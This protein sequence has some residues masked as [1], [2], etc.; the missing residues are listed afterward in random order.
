MERCP[1]Y[2]E[3]SKH[4]KAH[5]DP[6]GVDYCIHIYNKIPHKL[7]ANS[8]RY[9]TLKYKFENIY[10]T[11]C[12][13]VPII[14]YFKTNRNIFAVSA[15]NTFNLHYDMKNWSFKYVEDLCDY[16]DDNYP[17]LIRTNEDLNKLVN[18]VEFPPEEEIPDAPLLDD[19][20]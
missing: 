19:I 4:I 18:V 14:K 2:S 16:I 13:G 7:I 20:L 12:N 5:N 15:V 3:W 6:N 11:L 1:Y 10:C 17:E 9:L 8:F